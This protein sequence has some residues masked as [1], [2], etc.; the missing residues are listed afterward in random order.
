MVLMILVLDTTS[1]WQAMVAYLQ[2]NG[3]LESVVSK[4]PSQNHIDLLYQRFSYELFHLPDVFRRPDHTSKVV[5]KDSLNASL[6]PP[7]CAP[8]CGIPM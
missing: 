7:H 3:P 4:F 1:M 8:F 5:V 2:S 6:L